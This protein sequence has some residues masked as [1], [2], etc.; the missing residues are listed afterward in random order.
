MQTCMHVNYI[1]SHK[2]M[3]TAACTYIHTR[4]L[5]TYTCTL[6]NWTRIYT[7][8]LALEHARQGR[9]ELLEWGLG[10]GRVLPAEAEHWWK[11]A[12]RHCG[13]GKLPCQRRAQPCS[14]W[15]KFLPCWAR[16]NWMS[17]LLLVNAVCS[18]SGSHRNETDEP[19]CYDW[20]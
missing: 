20:D 11:W 6:V 7:H 5:K 3:H 14:A 16:H 12:V 2:Y 18:Y 15:G 4:A 9:Q 10:R 19:R 13:R 8:T 17:V 1:M